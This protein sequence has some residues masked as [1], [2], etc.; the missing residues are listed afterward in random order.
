M[1]WV[2][3]YV[4]GFKVPIS[5][6]KY[7]R[8]ASHGASRRRS[9]L[10]TLGVSRVL[11]SQL[12]SSRCFLLTAFNESS[13]RGNYRTAPPTANDA[14][15]RYVTVHSGARDGYQLTLALAE[16][17]MLEALVTDLYWSA[18]GTWARIAEMFLPDSVSDTL[19]RRRHPALYSKDVRSC[20]LAGLMAWVLGRL[21]HLPFAARRA[22]A[23]YADAVLGRT[24]ASLATRKGC[25][26]LSYSYY[27][28]DAFTHFAGGSILFQ[29]HPHPQS[30]RRILQGEI[31]AHPECAESLLQEWELSLPEEDFQRLAEE[32]SMAAQVLCASTFTRRTLIENGIP[33]AAIKVVPYGVDLSRFSPATD[34][35]MKVNGKLRL[36][37]VG[38][39]N[40]RKGV[41]YLLEALRLLGSSQVELT[42]C[43]RVVDTLEIFKPFANLITIRP[44]V[45]DSELIKTY[46]QADLFVFP[47]VAEGFGQVLLESL[48][49]GL[50]ILSTTHTAAPD[51]IEDGAQGFIIPPGDS[52]VLA[53]RID[54]A[55]THRPELAAMRQ[56][57]RMRAECFTWDRFRSGLVTAIRSYSSP[58]EHAQLQREVYTS[59]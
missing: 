25:G 56:P 32:S 23:R 15:G 59:V 36:L 51:L 11:H 37:F 27:A 30:M 53:E 4:L 40:Q 10:G 34:R 52:M 35:V 57:A 12:R 28:H 13:P 2:E 41:K 31:S 17:G 20:A 24:A 7:R 38:R 50:P 14:A 1:P 44:S 9:S 6:A 58:L 45:S 26:L 21:P 43:G 46:Q 48:A 49:C 39:I 22:A 19:R 18:D 3:G 42:L 55:L 33:P 47:S 54:W 8:S 16:A 29:L 5:T